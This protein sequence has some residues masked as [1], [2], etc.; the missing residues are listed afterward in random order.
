VQCRVVVV[1]KKICPKEE[2]F[3]LPPSKRTGHVNAVESRCCKR[4]KKW[5]NLL[6]LMWSVNEGV[7][8]KYNWAPVMTFFKGKA[9]V[10]GKKFEDRGSIPLVG[11]EK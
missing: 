5:R 1:R 11:R 4:W 9:E 2:K 10:C 3:K 6:D 7:V 8:L